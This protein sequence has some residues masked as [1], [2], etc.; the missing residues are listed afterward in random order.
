MTILTN[1]QKKHKKIQGYGR[2]V[3]KFSI[4]VILCYT[5][6]LAEMLW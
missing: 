3:Y 5:L 6:I 1:G 2:I 4:A